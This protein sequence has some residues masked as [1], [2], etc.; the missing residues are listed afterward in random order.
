MS[1]FLIG[2][3]LAGIGGGPFAAYILGDIRWFDTEKQWLS[4]RLAAEQAA[5]TQVV[6]ILKLCRLVVLDPLSEIVGAVDGRE[7]VADRAAVSDPIDLR[8]PAPERLFQPISGLQR[9]TRNHRICIE[10][11]RHSLFLQEQPFWSD[12]PDLHAA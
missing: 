8:N 3:G 5:R 10:Q 2:L 11:E 7:C 1:R 9:E 4:A 6:N 12:L